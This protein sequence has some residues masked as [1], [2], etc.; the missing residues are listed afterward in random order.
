MVVHKVR[1][2]IEH[3][4]GSFLNILHQHSC[5]PTILRYFYLLELREHLQDEEALT[6]V[7][8]TH[9]LLIDVANEGQ[10]HKINLII[11]HIAQH[12]G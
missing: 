3:F 1:D 8:L 10:Q 5:E 6:A 4:F 12:K 11:A 7:P 2:D 9:H